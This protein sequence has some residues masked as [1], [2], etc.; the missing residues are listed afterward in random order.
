[1]ALCHCLTIFCDAKYK[2]EKTTSGAQV[3]EKKNAES[4]RHQ[5]LPRR[6]NLEGEDL[7]ADLLQVIKVNICYY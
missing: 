6:K 3:T 5:S 4:Y 1:M 2:K 7:K